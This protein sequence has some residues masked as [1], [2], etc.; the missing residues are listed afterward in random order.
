MSKDKSSKSN[1]A[2]ILAVIVLLVLLSPL[3][4][5]LSVGPVLWL[6]THGHFAESWLAIYVPLDN[7]CNVSPAFEL[8]LEW[9]LQLWVE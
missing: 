4:Y 6:H 3:L 8:F 1:A 5:V 7:L 9:Y 2:A